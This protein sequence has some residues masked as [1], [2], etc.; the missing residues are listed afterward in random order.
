M[1]VARDLSFPRCHPLG[2]RAYAAMPISS[3]LKGL[4]HKHNDRQAN[5]PS[6]PVAASASAAS[7]HSSLPSHGASS[8]VNSSIAQPPA[9]HLA[10]VNAKSLPVTA[11]SNANAT[12]SPSGKA[13]NQQPA[14][15]AA[16]AAAAAT[17]N[18]TQQQQNNNN[19]QA[20]AENLVRKDA[21]AKAKREQS[22]FDGLPEGLT[23]GRKMGDGAFSNVFEATY[24]P[25]PAQL[26][27][28]PKLAKEVKVAVKCVRKFE[29][30]SSQV[31]TPVFFFLSPRHQCSRVI[32][33]STLLHKVSFG[34]SHYQNS[35]LSRYK[36][37]EA[38]LGL[39]RRPAPT[40]TRSPKPPPLPFPFT[41]N[42][43]RHNP[44]SPP[45]LVTDG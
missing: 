6:A 43:L 29:L 26:A 19:N 36:A 22:V 3:V 45:P 9:A 7:P 17:A 15:A 31:R 16:S 10:P 14:D 25:S 1:S 20:Q 8:D 13:M 27:V 2:Q 42:P 18:S 4:L 5:P 39:S 37:A 38:H 30:N 41:S 32:V 44:N 21:E 24:R 28:D 23:L 34:R 11:S 33:P 35:Y 40:P 12:A